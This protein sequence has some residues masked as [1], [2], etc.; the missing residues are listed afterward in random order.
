[1]PRDRNQESLPRLQGHSTPSRS[2]PPLQVSRC[3]TFLS[4]NKEAALAFYG[5]LRAHV[6]LSHVT[7][8]AA[9]LLK[10]VFAAAGKPQ[11]SYEATHLRW[12][13]YL[14]EG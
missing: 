14:V 9:M 10:V 8:L 13:S 1:M 11:V 3:L 5:S 12:S 6:S 4:Q 2:F 7:K